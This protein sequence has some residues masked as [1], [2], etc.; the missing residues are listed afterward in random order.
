MI[1]YRH[2]ILIILSY[3]TFLLS[4]C[5]S[6]HVHNPLGVNELPDIYPDYIDITIPIN[7]SPMNFGIKNDD[8]DAIEVSFTGSQ[9]DILFARGKK[10]IDI[11]RKKWEKLL[12][13]NSNDSLTVAVYAHKENGWYAFQP[14][15]LYIVSDS[16]DYSIV[17]RLIA[18]GYQT[19]SKMGIYQR[20][21][22]DYNQTSLY[23]NTQVTNS[24]VNCHTFC[25]GDPQRSS[26]H[27]RG[28]YG[29]TILQIDDK[30]IS[31]ESRTDSTLGTAVYPYWHP[32]GK[33]IVYSTNHVRQLFHTTTT[34]LIETFDMNS[35]IYIYDINS[36]QIFYNQAIKNNDF[37]ETNPAFSADGKSLYFCRASRKEMPKEVTTI[38]YDLC[39]IDF[40]PEN[41]SLGEKIDT[42]IL[43]SDKGKSISLPRPTSDG[44][45]VVYTQTDYGCF[46]LY[47]KEA[48]LWI[49][50]LETLETSPMTAINSE[51]ADAFHNFSSNDRWLVFGSRRQDGLH[52]RPY[53]AY[54]DDKG[55]GRK[56]FLLPQRNPK[57]YYD[58]LMLSYNCVEFVNGPVNFDSRQAGARLYSGMHQQMEVAKNK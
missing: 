13:A 9:G 30:M 19:Y 11:D 40:N 1:R 53:F 4:A 28:K 35:D 36:N 48:D 16:I 52:T 20:S 5:D 27:F 33:Y 34:N 18:P 24:C 25:K 39:R 44:K 56:A 22:S 38:R 2:H 12:A 21:L 58:N 46:P 26:V 47:H 51:Y 42:L 50:N 49:L 37:F 45:F 10:S 8:Y 15:K 14:F 29:A 54:V 43:T 31:L 32:S 3:I 6:N 17:Y 55:I 7:I 57:E 23:E 41:G